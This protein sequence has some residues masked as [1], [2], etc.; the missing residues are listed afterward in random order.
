MI[1][2]DTEKVTGV[3]KTTRLIIEELKAYTINGH[4]PPVSIED[5]HFVIEEMQ[6]IKIEKKEVIQPAGKIVR[7]SMAR[8]TDRA[9]ILVDSN[10]SDVLKRFTTA[11]E[12]CQIAIDTPADFSVNPH[13]TIKA[14]LTTFEL[15]NEHNGDH[16]VSADVVLSEIL[17]EIAALEVLYPLDLRRIDQKAVQAKKTTWSALEAQYRVPRYYIERA[18]T[19]PYQTL[20]DLAERIFS[21]EIL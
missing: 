8:F 7:G 3:L 21:G 9:I 5:L 4:A 6:K 18:F 17:A 12:L 19:A 2:M 16:E 1:L 15:D 10:L 20:T 14:L 13:E 11:K